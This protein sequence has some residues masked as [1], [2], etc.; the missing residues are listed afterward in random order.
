VTDDMMRGSA[1]LPHGWGH[2]AAD[3]LKLA[4]RSP[5]VNVNVL[6]PLGVEAADSLSGMSHVTGIVVNVRPAVDARLGNKLPQSEV[7][8]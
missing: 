2:Q 1:A 4:Q 6:T 5:G 3:G 8:A 7:N